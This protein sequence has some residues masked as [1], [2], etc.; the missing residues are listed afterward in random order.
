MIGEALAALKSGKYDP[1]HTA[2]G[3]ENISVNAVLPL[4]RSFEKSVG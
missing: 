1:D 3:M 2:I 4:Q